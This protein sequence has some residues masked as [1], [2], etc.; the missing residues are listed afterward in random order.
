MPAYLG[1]LL[2]SLAAMVMITKAKKAFA[3]R[4][5]EVKIELPAD[6][7]KIGGRVRISYDEEPGHF[8]PPG[9]PSKVSISKAQEGEGPNGPLMQLAYRNLVDPEVFL[10]PIQEE[11]EYLLAAELF[12]C[13]S[14]GV[15]D[16][17]K[18]LLSRK[19][20]VKEG[21]PNESHLPID[22]KAAAQKGLEAGMETAKR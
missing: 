15:A 6:S 4:F 10:G 19:I 3:P 22:L 18:L 1:G 2:I 21:R 13:A 14:P 16:C 12:V 7:M 9:F 5:H 8:L 20:S 11:G 17:A